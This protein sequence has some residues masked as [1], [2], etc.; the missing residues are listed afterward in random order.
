MP[1]NTQIIASCSIA[2]GAVPSEVVLLPIG[3]QMISRRR[4]H[5]VERSGRSVIGHRLHRRLGVEHCPLERQRV[6]AEGAAVVPLE[7][8]VAVEVDGEG[9]DVVVEAELAHGP[10]HVL[11]RD[12]LPL[13]PLAPLVRLAGDEA[14]VLRHALLDRLLRVVGDL[15]VGR[16]HLPH[17]PDHVG[18]RHEAVLLPHGALAAAPGDGAAAP[19]VAA[20]AA[21]PTI[22]RLRRRHPAA[23]M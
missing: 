14:D 10:E 6:A 4:L 8:A 16:E 22:G 21:R 20:V 2:G 12:R 15:G 1:V 5:P 19:G 7:L 11:R 3:R 13:L 17:D 23:C 9:F 18:D